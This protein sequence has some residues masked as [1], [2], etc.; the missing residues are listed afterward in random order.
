MA[1]PSDGQV[2]DTREA[3]MRDF[4]TN[5][6]RNEYLLNRLLFKYEYGENVEDVF[7][8]RPFFDRLTAPVLRALVAQTITPESRGRAFGIFFFVTSIATLL[9]SVLTGQ[10]W[11]YFGARM[12][13]T[14]SALLALAAAAMLLFAPGA[15]ES[16]TSN[17]DPGSNMRRSEQKLS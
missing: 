6:Q 3:L 4:E 5:S 9:A 17:I 14:L 2:A 13:L 15:S 11:K 12:P 8:M 16:P 7:N 10:L 1:G